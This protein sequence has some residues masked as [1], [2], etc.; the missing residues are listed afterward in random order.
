[1]AIRVV[2]PFCGEIHNVRDEYAGMQGRCAK[3]REIFDIPSCDPIESELSKLAADKKKG[4]PATERQKEY[5]KKLGIAFSEDIDRQSISRLIDDA[6][7]KRD[8]ERWARLSALQDKESEEYK[9]TRAEIESQMIAEDPPLSKSTIEQVVKT[10]EDRQIPA[11]LITMNAKDIDKIY[12]EDLN[13]QAN[14][15]FTDSYL[16]Q[17]DVY[18]RISLLALQV[19]PSFRTAIETIVD[20]DDEDGDY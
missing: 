20:E 17:E 5:A 12:D 3:C 15:N 6:Q 9:R 16:T 13:L 18:H 7:Q 11:I 4:P 8:E 2:C 19:N 14:M 10:F 1:M